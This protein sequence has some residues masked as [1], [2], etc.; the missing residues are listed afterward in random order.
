[1]ALFNLLFFKSGSPDEDEIDRLIQGLLCV[2]GVVF[3]FDQVSAIIGFAV[4]I[5]LFVILIF[6]LA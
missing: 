1:M 4:T 5:I 6:L 2:F 3:V